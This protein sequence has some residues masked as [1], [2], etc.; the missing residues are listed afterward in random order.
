MSHC[1]TLQWELEIKACAFFS[2][3]DYHRTVGRIPCA[4]CVYIITESLCYTAE[5]NKVVL[6]GCGSDVREYKEH[7][8]IAL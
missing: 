7:K 8:V 6:E 1:P 3:I 2:Y 4:G 5:I